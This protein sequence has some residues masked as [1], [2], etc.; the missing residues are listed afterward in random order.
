[1]TTFDHDFQYLFER[2]LPK[3]FPDHRQPAHTLPLSQLLEKL[4]SEPDWIPIDPSIWPP[5][6]ELLLQ[7][8]IIVQNPMDHQFIRSAI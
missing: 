6:L 4:Y 3:Y 5:H 7:S 8:G 1:M 2:F